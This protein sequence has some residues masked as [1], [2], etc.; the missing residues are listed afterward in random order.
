MKKKIFL[1]ILFI[2]ATVYINAQN[3]KAQYRFHSINSLVLVNGWA[4]PAASIQSVNGFKK[5][6][7]F[8]GVGAGIDYYR[9]RTVPLFADIR[10][11]A[12]KK[13]NKFFAYANA[14]INFTWVQ[15]YLI[16]EPTIWNN[17]TSNDFKNG[18]YTDAGIGY[19]VGMKNENA[20]VLSLGYSQKNLSEI[21]TYQWRSG[22]WF[23][24]KNT[25][26]LNRIMLKAGWKF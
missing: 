18:L 20:F 19:S 16:I 8:A 2:P 6:R 23:T 5:G 26:H 17:N 21:S 15:D 13:I 22:E 11:E 14:G 10:Y 1:L 7:W 24:T 25:Y 9:Y 3:N 12:G 4:G